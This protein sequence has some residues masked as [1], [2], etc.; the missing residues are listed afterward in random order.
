MKKWIVIAWIASLLA[1]TAGCVSSAT[2][3]D[4]FQPGCGGHAAE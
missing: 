3:G 1:L 2:G 4:V